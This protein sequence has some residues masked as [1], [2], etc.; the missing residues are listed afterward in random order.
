MESKE[1]KTKQR[2]Q[3]RPYIKFLD[4]GR[5]P[6]PS[7]LPVSMGRYHCWNLASSEDSARVLMIDQ[8]PDSETVPDIDAE[9]YNWVCRAS[10]AN[11]RE[12]GTEVVFD[13]SR[14]L[15]W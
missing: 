8:N 10:W 9:V 6:F 13:N 5:S 2:R 1:G 11:V 12:M 4:A 7:P 3:N 14:I 15:V